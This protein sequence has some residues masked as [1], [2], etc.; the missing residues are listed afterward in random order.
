M[1][2][3]PRPSRRL[4]KVNFYNISLDLFANRLGEQVGF[5]PKPKS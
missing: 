1:G 3:K 4:E 2:L 5:C